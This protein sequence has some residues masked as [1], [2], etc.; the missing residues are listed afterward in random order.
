[1]MKAVGLIVEYNPF[2]NGHLWHLNEAKR[3]SGAPFAI[4]V[5]SGNFTQRGEPAMTDKWSRAAMAVKAGV[6][7]IV[8]L[9]VVFSVR[10]AQYFA[11]GGIRLLN[12]LGVVSHVCFGAEMPDM[13]KLLAAANA[14]NQP[15]VIT[16]MREQMKTGQTYAASLAA[17]VSAS[18]SVDAGLFQSP[19]NLLAIEYVRAINTYAPQIVPLPLKRLAADYHDSLITSPI[20]SATAIRAAILQKGALSPG[21]TAWQ[22][23]PPSCARQINELISTGK[24]P[25]TLADFSNIIL[26][27]IRAM[28]LDALAG[29]PDITEGLHN[30]INQAAFKATTVQELLAYSKSKRYTITRLQRI[31]VHAL[32]ET[33][34]DQL[35][36]FDQSGPLYARIL[37]F[38]SNGRRL[39]KEIS[40]QA[41]IPL[42][43]K[44][45]HYLTSKQQT[46]NSLSPLQAM[47]A[48]DI[49]A[50][51]IY[52]LGFPNP[53]WRAGNQDY[54]TS[55]LYIADE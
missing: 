21:S 28:R 31:I 33:T 47:L 20:A 22:A 15:A 54:Q 52:A 5:M 43:T 53:L 24:V 36:Q 7:L 40:Q 26:A 19:N 11:T 17:A 51:D 25:V 49:S 30:K 48:R 18:A 55:P 12:H 32:L 10:S 13:A 9:P 44:T 14:L 3:I 37:A 45:A 39:L 29:L 16:A 4:G 35:A 38:N 50:T 34:K 2:H 8:E 42:I 46:P 23:L 41:T 6:D 27:K 1:M